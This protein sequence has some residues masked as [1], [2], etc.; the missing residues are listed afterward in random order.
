MDSRGLNQRMVDVVETFQRVLDSIHAADPDVVIHA[1]DFFDKDRP[2]NIVIIT[3]YKRLVKFQKLREGKPFILVA[4]NH[5]SPKAVGAGNILSIFGEHLQT[6]YSIPGVYVVETTPRRIEL[7]EIGFEA[8]CI[9]W[10]GENSGVDMKPL[11]K[12]NSSVII[13]HGLDGALGLPGATLSLPR[14]HYQEWDYV[15]LGDFHIRKELAPNAWYCGSTDYTSTNF[16]EEDL[17][18]GWN[19]F[20]TESRDVRFMPVEP[21]RARVPLADIDATGLSGVDIGD[22]LLRNAHW[23]DGSLPMVRQC[24]RNCSPTSRAEVPNRIRL[25]LADRCLHYQL[26]MY[27]APKDGEKGE[28]KPRGAT[29]NEDWQNYAEARDLPLGLDRKEFVETGHKLMKEAGSDSSEN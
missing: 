6:E 7:P 20:D 11:D 9:P 22:E 10:G 13:A 4:G 23:E 25:D 26:D 29:L 14:M 8:L 19:L 27:L 2:P 28:A 16:W 3:A 5:D 15:A 24:V 12:R 1:G 18:K 17:Q 21:A